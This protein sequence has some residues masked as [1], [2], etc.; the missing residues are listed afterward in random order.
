MLGDALDNY[1]LGGVT[2]D[3][4]D[5]SYFFAFRLEVEDNLASR[6]G[7]LVSNDSRKESYDSS[8]DLASAITA[9]STR[10]NDSLNYFCGLLGIDCFFYA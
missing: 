6:A 2:D 10:L 9:S 4:L 3:N 8:Y 1:F 7:V 5:Y